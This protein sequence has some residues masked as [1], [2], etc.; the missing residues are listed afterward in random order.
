MAER[1]VQTIKNI[2]RKVTEDKKDLYLALLDFRNIPLGDD[3]GSP[4]QR[5]MGRRTKTLLP[6]SQNLLMP[7]QIRPQTVKGK[8]TKQKGNMINKQKHFSSSKL[9][10]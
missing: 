2:L 4:V 9:V 7:K 8:I 5:L 1:A 10:T 3:T 6:T